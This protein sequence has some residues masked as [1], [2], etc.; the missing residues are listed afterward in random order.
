MDQHERSCNCLL[1]VVERIFNTRGSTR[2]YMADSTK[3]KRYIP[4]THVPRKDRYDTDLALACQ[5]KFMLAITT[6]WPRHH[7]NNEV[8]ALE[9]FVDGWLYLVA[10]SKVLFCNPDFSAVA[11]K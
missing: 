11:F 8:G 9:R 5:I 4:C 6:H 1:K 3:L 10:R 7:K 2:V